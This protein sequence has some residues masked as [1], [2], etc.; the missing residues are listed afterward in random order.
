MGED[1][2]RTPDEIKSDE[3][4]SDE[5][6]SDEIKSDEIKSDEIKSDEIKSELEAAIKLLGNEYSQITIHKSDEGFIYLYKNSN[7][8]ITSI[9]QA[10]NL[11]IDIYEKD[12]HD[13]DDDVLIYNSY[14]GTRKMTNYIIIKNIKSIRTHNKKKNSIQRKTSRPA[15][16]STST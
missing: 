4:K 5:I 2:T 6:K 13:F 11:G 15:Y 1:T 10:T 3:I 12:L 16:K 8:Y 7:A 14:F 9:I